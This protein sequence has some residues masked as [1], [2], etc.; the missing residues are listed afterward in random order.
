MKPTYSV[1]ILWSYERI[2]MLASH[3]Q[4]C[5]WFLFSLVWKRIE[6]S[7]HLNI[8][9]GMCVHSF[10]SF[11]VSQNP[12]AY[13]VCIRDSCLRRPTLTF[14]ACLH[15]KIYKWFPSL[16]NLCLRM[17]VLKEAHS[18]MRLLLLFSFRSF[19]FSKCGWKPERNW[20]FVMRLRNSVFFSI[21]LAW[22]V[23]H[24]ATMCGMKLFLWLNTN[25]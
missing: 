16:L 2:H 18:Y 22:L 14:A 4:S 11:C 12:W 5:F 13:L 9:L 23:L 7:K 15:Q 21:G 3:L 25:R 1:D 19:S 20:N 17:I 10:T 8:F 6:N 24:S